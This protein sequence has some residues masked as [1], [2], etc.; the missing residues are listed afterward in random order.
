[1]KRLT[2]ILP[3]EYPNK[4]PVK[5]RAHK[6]FVALPG[7]TR[8]FYDN[9]TVSTVYVSATIF[10]HHQVVG[11][12]IL[13]FS[14]YALVVDLNTVNYIHFLSKCSEGYALFAIQRSFDFASALKLK[15]NYNTDIWEVLLT[16]K[17]I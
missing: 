11:N 4:I 2:V 14:M 5:S 13:L 16:V 12:V 7:D 8:Q 15:R 10:G 3:G 9:Y 1:V 6:L 17:K